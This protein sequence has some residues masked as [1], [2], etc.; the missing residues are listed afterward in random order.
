MSKKL[1]SIGSILLILFSTHSAESNQIIKVNKD[2]KTVTIDSGIEEGRLVA[3][4]NLYVLSPEDA[5]KGIV[6]L[7]KTDKHT[8]KGKIIE[9]YSD[10]AVGDKVIVFGN[11]LLPEKDSISCHKQLILDQQSF[12][13]FLENS[14]GVK[15]LAYQCKMFKDEAKKAGV[16]FFPSLEAQYV[17]GHT[18]QEG[19]RTPD[20][21]V[22]DVTLDVL[23]LYQN[24]PFAEIARRKYYICLV[25]KTSLELEKL[26]SELTLRF[27]HLINSYNAALKKTAFLK[28]E[29]QDI[30]QQLKQLQAKENIYPYLL[31]LLDAKI[32]E[33]KEL[34][35]IEKNTSRQMLAKIHLALNLSPDTELLFPTPE[36]LLQELKDLLHV[37]EKGFNLLLAEYDLQI[38][39]AEYELAKANI[40][41]SAQL[42]IG[43]PSYVSSYKLIIP[44]TGRAAIKAAELE[45]R[46]ALCNLKQ[47]RLKTAFEMKRISTE[48]HSS[49]K[50][51]LRYKSFKQKISQLTSD[52]W[53]DELDIKEKTARINE[54]IEKLNSRITELNIELLKYGNVKTE[55]EVFLDQDLPT[56]KSCLEYAKKMS[57][58][59]EYLWLEAR[60]SFEFLKESKAEH[61][62]AK[63][64][65]Y[66]DEYISKATLKNLKIQELQSNLIKTYLE[67]LENVFDYQTS[68]KLT[69]I[70][71]REYEIKS[72]DKNIRPY[73]IDNS[74]LIWQEEL[75]K[76]T[77]KA[78]LKN[79]NWLKLKY[80]LSNLKDPDLEFYPKIQKDILKETADT[81]SNVGFDSNIRERLQRFKVLLAV[82]SIEVTKRGYW[83]KGPWEVVYIPRKVPSR[84]RRG[85]DWKPIPHGTTIMDWIALYI[86]TGIIYRTP[87][88][89]RIH[90]LRIAHTNLEIAKIR[91]E[92]ESIREEHLKYTI[93]KTRSFR[94]ENLKE[95]ELM[96]QKVRNR[97]LKTKAKI[98]N[99][100]AREIDLLAEQRVVLEKEFDQIKKLRLVLES[101]TD[102]LDRGRPKEMFVSK[103]KPLPVILTDIPKLKIA[104]KEAAIVREKAKKEWKLN[105]VDILK[106]GRLSAGPWLLLKIF[107][108]I[109][110][111]RANHIAK[112][113]PIWM[114]KAAVDAELEFQNWLTRVQTA[115]VKIDSLTLLMQRVGY[116][117]KEVRNETLLST[118]PYSHYVEL[119]LLQDEIKNEIDSERE[120]KLYALMQLKTLTGTPLTED[121]LIGNIEIPY[122]KL[123]H[124][125]SPGNI[126]DTA[127]EDFPDIKLAESKLSLAYKEK[128]WDHF[129]RN[130]KFGADYLCDIITTRVYTWSFTLTVFDLFLHQLGNYYQDKIQYQ[131][132][133]LGNERLKVEKDIYLKYYLIHNYR[134]R[135]IEFKRILN[136]YNSLLDS[137]WT[138]YLN[139]QVPWESE[140]G[141]LKI[142]RKIF[143]TQDSFIDSLQEYAH[144]LNYYKKL[145]KKYF[146]E[147]QKKPISIAVPFSILT[148]QNINLNKIALKIYRVLSDLKHRLS[149]FKHL[150]LAQKTYT[151]NRRFWEEKEQKRN[152]NLFTYQVQKN[153]KKT[154]RDKISK[155]YAQAQET[156]YQS[157]LVMEKLWQ[158]DYQDYTSLKKRMSTLITPP[159]E[160]E[161]KHQIKRTIEILKPGIQT[162]QN[163]FIPFDEND[164][165]NGLTNYFLKYL[166]NL[167]F[168][169]KE[170]ELFFRNLP[171]IAS[172]WRNLKGN[173]KIKLAGWWAKYSGGFTCLFLFPYFEPDDVNELGLVVHYSLVSVW[174]QADSQTPQDVLGRIKNRLYNEKKF[175]L[176]NLRTLPQKDVFDYLKWQNYL[177]K[178]IDNILFQHFSYNEIETLRKQLA[179]LKVPFW[180][181]T[182]GNKLEEQ[183]QTDIIRWFITSG[184]ADRGK[185]FQLFQSVPQI[186]YRIYKEPAEDEIAHSYDAVRLRHLL[187]IKDTQNAAIE[188]KRLKTS[189]MIGLILFWLHKMELENISIEELKAIV[190]ETAEIKKQ[191]DFIQLYGNHSLTDEQYFFY[192]HSLIYYAQ[193][194]LISQNKENMG[195]TFF[196]MKFLKSQP[197]FISLYGN[198]DF[199]TPYIYE[200]F[201]P[202]QILY[203]TGNLSFWSHWSIENGFSGKFVKDFLSLYSRAVKENSFR[204]TLESI[205]EKIGIKISLSL[206]GK[207]RQIQKEIY[208]IISNWVIYFYLRDI[209]SWDTMLASLKEISAMANL[210]LKYRLDYNQDDLRYWF[211]HKNESGYS[212]E[213]IEQIFYLMSRTKT[214]LVESV[215]S[216]RQLAEIKPYLARLKPSLDEIRNKK[217]HPGEIQRLAEEVLYPQ[218]I[219]VAELIEEYK[220]GVLIQA[221]YLS[222]LHAELTP[223]QVSEIFTFFKKEGL[224]IKDLIALIETEQLIYHILE[225]NKL[226]FIFREP[227]LRK[228]IWQNAY[229]KG[230]KSTR[231]YFRKWGLKSIVFLK[232]FHKEHNYY[233]PKRLLYV[234]LDYH[235]VNAPDWQL[236]R[237]IHNGNLSRAASN[238][239]IV[240]LR[241][242]W[243]IK[244]ELLF[245]CYEHLLLGVNVGNLNPLL[246]YFLP[247]NSYDYQPLL[248]LAKRFEENM[249][250][251]IIADGKPQPD[252]KMKEII[253]LAFPMLSYVY[254]NED[255]F[256]KRILEFSQRSK[257][258]FKRIYP[259]ISFQDTLDIPQKRI[260]II[261]RVK[262]TAL[263]HYNVILSP[264]RT[265]NIIWKMREGYPLKAALK[266]FIG[267]YARLKEIY[268]ATVSKKV[269]GDI[270]NLLLH[271]SQQIYLTPLEIE[272]CKEIFLIMRQLQTIDETGSNVSLKPSQI[273]RNA[274][275]IYFT[276]LKAEDLKIIAEFFRTAK[277]YLPP[278]RT[279]TAFYLCL[280]SF[281]SRP[282]YIPDIAMYPY[283][284]YCEMLSKTDAPDKN[285]IPYLN[286]NNISPQGYYYIYCSAKYYSLNLNLAPGFEKYILAS[287]LYEKTKDTYI[288]KAFL[289]LK[290]D[291][292]VY[293]YLKKID[294]ILAKRKRNVI[295]RVILKE[296]RF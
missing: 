132:L 23:N 142:F 153:R 105:L 189:Y 259:D 174:N 285:I 130:L 86:P 93:L 183:L 150:N 29:L 38:K 234:L 76:Q 96:L 223:Y 295:K 267:D 129:A 247:L 50:L 111:I 271:L 255:V 258:G 209:T 92:Q 290:T 185:M 119:E 17:R 257:N 239:L 244:R 214:I 139:K 148:I 55:P 24:L 283:Q 171:Q 108:D 97:Y 22:P 73:L 11:T 110:I 74:K 135:A 79:L 126:I 151:E 64:N 159:Y 112:E 229:N 203:Y 36:Q 260:A 220:I 72:A 53:Q 281:K 208:G 77:E 275:S 289:N 194:N 280:K 207:N 26:K 169:E 2:H 193:K 270:N 84:G 54:R 34:L 167:R 44:I 140:Y 68:T 40:R 186:L 261:K 250:Q 238:P 69:K 43:Y 25:G 149:L 98:K 175:L 264:A 215:E 181:Y 192:Q 67:L 161:Y 228:F 8:S 33:K 200:K 20:G 7:E 268:Q 231:Q 117:L 246:Y 1:L 232:E 32:T 296:C 133:L 157:F 188:Y 63:Q 13:S 10:I 163:L 210:S 269:T 190:K 122:Q 136:S 266:I 242:N 15:M 83:I 170:I 109:N 245:F 3:G 262:R 293:A 106:I 196:W 49:R 118:A 62:Y 91:M 138:S 87:F 213:E 204:E 241:R 284:D 30:K 4:I 287:L 75:I 21:T 217:M 191:P 206:K 282:Y 277:E 216:L 211:Q 31:K 265:Y 58:E 160:D 291:A 165:Y 286:K 294:K 202:F 179:G 124:L 116:Y 101:E 66:Q 85:K 14:P 168:S 131:N 156:E 107:P 125:T 137:A 199:N 155:I 201:A 221:L 205:Y 224:G 57:P 249:A 180:Q 227:E 78:L 147:E 103:T 279:N 41:P 120:R 39:Q 263:K 187:A 121:L 59:S 19:R 82:D 162:E 182:E 134:A 144:N 273:Y 164:L 5:V 99:F 90:D 28:E 94:K 254:K 48:L 65:F 212:Q 226:A 18:L 154:A 166:H 178:E 114:D 288:V 143:K 292:E 35:K 123:P 71:R 46:Q 80:Y 225:K 52:Y 278:K 243:N 235:T 70:Y 16:K 274:E 236:K 102:I 176:A 95:S 47:E 198:I 146:H 172:I 81:I 237:L 219:T 113:A 6:E 89:G 222:E 61:N 100:Q 141:L 184:A 233:P 51:L 37:P 42:K 56:L 127:T 152:F 9:E 276:G 45:K 88:G 173:K 240:N 177:I 145:E 230:W 218:K 251:V 256:K 27:L 12:L 128:H 195:K 115:K 158:Q 60:K 252:E 248:E 272:D 104:E 197:E 253:P